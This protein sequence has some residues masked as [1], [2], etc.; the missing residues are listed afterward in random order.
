M[1]V[2]SILACDFSILGE[3]IKETE[4]AGAEILHIDVMDGVFVPS[5]S[6]GMPLIKSIRKDSGLFFDCHLMIVEPERYFKAFAECGTDGI[7]FHEEA[8]KDVQAAIDEI[9]ALGM[10]AGLSIKPGTPVES[11]EP[12]VPS[13]DLI[14]VMTVEPGFGAQKFLE[15]SLERIRAVRAMIDRIKP[16]CYLQIDGG[17]NLD[18]L[19]EAKKA[20]TDLFVCGS[21]VYQNGKITDNLRLLTETEQKAQV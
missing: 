6:F 3:L 11:L 15:G 18:T 9:H 13:L 20:G 10:K 1:I 12:Y 2:P 16:G 21:A 14:L 17:V 8:C 4:A 19:A 5:I 7:T